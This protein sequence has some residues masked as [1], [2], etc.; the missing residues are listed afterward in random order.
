[1]L[2]TSKENPAV[3]LF[4]KLKEQKKARA[5]LGLFV[6]EGIRICTDALN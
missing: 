1:M 2:I 3:K 6:I 5:E 4:I